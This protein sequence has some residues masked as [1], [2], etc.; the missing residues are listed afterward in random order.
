MRKL[1]GDRR[2]LV[3]VDASDP[4]MEN[5]ASSIQTRVSMKVLIEPCGHPAR[6]RGP[7]D[8]RKGFG[9]HLKALE[10]SLRRVRQ[11]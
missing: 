3:G 2:L 4:A 11:S 8:A 9:E 6:A 7:S 1:P 10:S 5:R